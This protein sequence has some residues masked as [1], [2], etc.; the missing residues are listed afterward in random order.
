[1]GRG[2]TKEGPTSAFCQPLSNASVT[3][4]SSSDSVTNAQSVSDD[5]TLAS[6]LVSADPAVA[7]SAKDSDIPDSEPSSACSEART[8]LFGQFRSRVQ[9]VI[10]HL[11]DLV[12]EV[13]RAGLEEE[14]LA[15]ASGKFFNMRQPTPVHSFHGPAAAAAAAVAAR[16]PA[17]VLLDEVIG[18]GSEGGGCVWPEEDSP[19]W[20]WRSWKGVALYDDS[21][22]FT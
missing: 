5:T 4:Q 9:R 14:R 11:K 18:A 10:Q 2:A 6:G 20:D 8:A 3:T 7:A 22:F 13:D 19:V 17:P 16:S 12:K 15:A 21:A 1:M